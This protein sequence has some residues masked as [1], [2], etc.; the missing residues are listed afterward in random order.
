MSGSSL[1]AAVSGPPT[2]PRPLGL[3]LLLLLRLLPFGELPASASA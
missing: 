1:S 2:E 3:L